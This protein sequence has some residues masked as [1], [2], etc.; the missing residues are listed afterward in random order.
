MVISMFSSVDH[1]PSLGQVSIACAAP[2]AWVCT[3]C[4]RLCTHHASAS[5]YL[6]P[7][8]FTGL[9]YTMKWHK[10]DSLLLGSQALGTIYICIYIVLA[11]HM[12]GSFFFTTLLKS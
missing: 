12:D 3:A 10:L 4:D 2:V 8:Y 11:K 6:A 7:K 9:F 5:P 1:R